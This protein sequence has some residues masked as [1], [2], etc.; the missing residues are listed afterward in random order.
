MGSQP[1]KGVCGLLPLEDR[2]RFLDESRRICDELILVEPTSE[3]VPS[4]RAE[5]WEDRGLSDGSKYEIY[6]GYFTT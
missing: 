1:G 5:E 3:W 6:R 2:G 4:D